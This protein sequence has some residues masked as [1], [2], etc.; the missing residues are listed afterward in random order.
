M[1]SAPVT[2]GR[3]RTHSPDETRVPCSAVEKLHSKSQLYA[4]PTKSNRCQ[5]N[6]AR[7][8]LSFST[9]RLQVEALIGP[10]ILFLMVRLTHVFS[11][12]G[13]PTSWGTHLISVVRYP[14]L[15]DHL[16]CRVSEHSKCM[17]FVYVSCY[18][19]R[20]EVR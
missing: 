12:G 6:Y 18:A 13:S 9:A 16:S 15:L 17:D 2:Y 14:H 4:A 3:K 19:V 8:F 1:P 10:K 5:I 7:F 11:L 20:C